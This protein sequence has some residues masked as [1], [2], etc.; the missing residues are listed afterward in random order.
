MARSL[1]A[2]QKDEKFC[3]RGHKPSTQARFVTDKRDQSPDTKQLVKDVLAHLGRMV[4]LVR[5]CENGHLPQSEL[6]AQIGR[7]LN[8]LPIPPC[9]HH[10]GKGGRADLLLQKGAPVVKMSRHSV[11]AIKDMVISLGTLPLRISIR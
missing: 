2:V 11:I 3:P 5:V 7:T 10:S 6:G 1:K 9:V 4:N 8:L